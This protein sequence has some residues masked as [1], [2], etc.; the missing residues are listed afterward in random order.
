[1]LKKI[2]GSIMSDK[3]ILALFEKWNKALQVGD[4]AKIA[5]L[6]ESNAILLPTVS[7]QV[8]HTQ[9]E[10]ED[11]FVH[12]AAKGP[13]GKIDEANVRTYGDIAINSGIYTFTFK[14][15][16]RVQARYTFVYRW[17]GQTWKIIEHHSSQ[18]P[19]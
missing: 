2:W 1:L 4:P 11:Y 17:N 15:G 5:D 10:R 13:N 9:A 8:R 19:E 16:N 6:Y 12:F 7:N 3:D 18:M 14:D